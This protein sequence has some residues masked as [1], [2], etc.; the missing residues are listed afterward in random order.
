MTTTVQRPILRYHGGK[1][2]LANWIISHFPVHRT[3]VEP[4][5]GAASVLLS[6][7]RSY[8][9]VYNEIDPEIVNLFSVCRDKGPELTEKLYH[10]PFSRDEFEL[11]YLPTPDNV[12]AARRTV[13]RSF[14]G[15]GS[16]IQSEQR[17]GFRANSNRSGTTPAQDWKNFPE[18][19]K[20]IIERLRGVVIENRYALEVMAS[21]DSPDTLHYLDPP[22][23]KDTRYKGQ[24]TKVYRHEMEDF[25]HVELCENIKKL[26]GFVVL[27]GYENE[28]YNEMLSDWTVVRK[29]TFADGAA[30]R[31]ECLYLNQKTFEKK[32]QKELYL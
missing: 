29:S 18:A 25:D 23:A 6:K 22:Y 24:R 30:P 5:G 28:I 15:F 26:S 10:T 32:N 17:T 27:S 7:K 31:V 20:A 14:F 1:W 11:S 13:V 4:Y 3:Y 21:H 9:E 19:L 12:E 8:A 2:L 16:G